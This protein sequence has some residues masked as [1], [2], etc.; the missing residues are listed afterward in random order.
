MTGVWVSD[1][2]LEH[3]RQRV[4]MCRRLARSTTDPKTAKILRDMAD[5][6]EL[7]LKKL[8]AEREA[9]GA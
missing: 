8:L 7:D 9:N 4:E 1:D 3:M 6:G 5:Q 2:P